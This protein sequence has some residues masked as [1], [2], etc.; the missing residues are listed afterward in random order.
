MSCHQEP[1]EM[2]TAIC[3][4]SPALFLAAGDPRVP[5]NWSCNPLK[6]H[7]QRTGDL[8]GICALSTVSKLALSPASKILVENESNQKNRGGRQVTRS[9]EGGF[10][11][12][13]HRTIQHNLFQPFPT[14]NFGLSL[15]L[16]SRMSHHLCKHMIWLPL[17]EEAKKPEGLL[18]ERFRHISLYRW[19]EPESLRYH[20]GHNQLSSILIFPRHSLSANRAAKPHKFPSLSTARWRD[21]ER[22]SNRVILQ[23]PKGTAAS[24]TAL[25]SP[26]TQTSSSSGDNHRAKGQLISCLIN[27]PHFSTRNKK[28]LSYLS[29]ERL[30]TQAVL[31]SG[32][33]W[34]PRGDYNL[35]FGME[36]GLVNVI[37]YAHK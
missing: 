34:H 16:C 37:S 22:R 25:P 9:G 17:K 31:L 13:G 21:I 35:K 23:L 28:E 11:V 7:Y 18:Q 14:L 30:E 15:L 6:T 29:G 20:T 8:Q 12:L 3:V 26:R 36:R 32:L 24:S 27:Q 4:S 2:A 19:S 1:H 33:V 5:A 10:D